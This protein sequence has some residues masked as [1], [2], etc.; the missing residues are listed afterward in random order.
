M[1]KNQKDNTKALLK[2]RFIAV[3]AATIVLSLL[4]F[5][6]LFMTMLAYPSSSSEQRSASE[7]LMPQTCDVDVTD[8]ISGGRSA[9]IVDNA[10]HVTPLGGKAIWDHQQFHGSHHCSAPE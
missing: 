9:M 3:I 8:Y 5:L 4:P 2:Q 7:R 6:L 1:R 10:L